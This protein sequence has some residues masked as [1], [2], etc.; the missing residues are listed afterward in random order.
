MN[1]DLGPSCLGCRHGDGRV[2]YWPHRRW[3]SELSA[4]DALVS[5]ARAR[6][7]GAEPIFG[8]GPCGPERRYFQ[9]GTHA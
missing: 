2:G 7:E 3:C 6:A 8:R 5:A 1:A 9:E 4:P